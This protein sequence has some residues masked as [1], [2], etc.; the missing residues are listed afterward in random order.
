MT[1]PFDFDQYKWAL[2]V[3]LAIVL[4]FAAD[5]LLG[6]SVGKIVSILGMEFRELAKTKWNVASI[7]AILICWGLFIG[8]FLVVSDTANKAIDL[9]RKAFGDMQANQLEES[10]SPLMLITLIFLYSLV[11]VYIVS[12]SVHR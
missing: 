10:L 11:S 8:T 4:L 3:A 9:V 7:N 1:P 6:I 2:H 5:K 12:R